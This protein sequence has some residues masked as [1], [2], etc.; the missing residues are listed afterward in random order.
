[1]APPLSP[2]VILAGTWQFLDCL[3]NIGGD[4]WAVTEVI[5]QQL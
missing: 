5:D 2:S 1:M 4:G 3:E